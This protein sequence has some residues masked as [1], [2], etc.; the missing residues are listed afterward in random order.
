MARLRHRDLLKVKAGL[1]LVLS[2]SRPLVGVHK[3][4][5]GATAA[6]AGPFRGSAALRKSDDASLIPQTGSGEGGIRTLGEISGKTALSVHGV[7]QSGALDP[8]NG[9]IDPALAS[10]IDA[11]PTLPE[12]IRAGILA[13]IRAAGG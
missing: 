3:P 9:P 12:P 8:K 11:W 10:L 6:P 5:V 2:W 7:A 4:S 13:M 1:E